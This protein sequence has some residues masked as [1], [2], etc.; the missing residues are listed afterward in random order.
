M[1]LMKKLSL[2]ICMIILIIPLTLVIVLK[3]YIIKADSLT[4]PV[5]NIDAHNISYKENI[6]LLYAISYENIND[7]NL[8]NVKLLVWRNVTNDY[9]IKNYSE[10]YDTKEIL[11]GKLIFRVTGN[12]VKDIDKNIYAR[13]YINVDNKDYYSEVEKYSILEY[14]QVG[15]NSESSTTDQ[16][17][18]YKSFLDYATNVQKVI[19][20][21][22]TTPFNGNW[23]RVDTNGINLN[24]GFNHDYLYEGSLLSLNS[25]ESDTN[26]YWICNNKLYNDSTLNLT[27][28]ENTTINYIS[29]ASYAT[30]ISNEKMANSNYKDNIFLFSYNE[31]ATKAAFQ[32]DCYKICLTKGEDNYYSIEYYIGAGSQTKVSTCDYVICIHSNYESSSSIYNQMLKNKRIEIYDNILVFYKN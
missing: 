10:K 26:P 25:N 12:S 27:I 6:E 9:T 5:L 13:A 14:Y 17:A 4:S 2:V 22:T 1:A 28:S 30:I 8:D 16:I 32:N 21:N 7:E 11:D 3:N 19:G 15:I 31:Y 24:D 20:K 18:L 29:S 23:Y